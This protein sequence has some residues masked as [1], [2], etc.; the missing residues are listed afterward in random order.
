MRVD[1][2]FSYVTQVILSDQEMNISLAHTWSKTV[3]KYCAKLSGLAAKKREEIK[4]DKYG[5]E[6]LPGGNASKCIPVVFEHF[7]TWEVATDRLLEHF[8]T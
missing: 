7:G 6:T 4:N 3:I 8:V 1:L 5:S 2:I